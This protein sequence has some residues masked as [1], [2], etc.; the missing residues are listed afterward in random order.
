MLVNPDGLRASTSGKGE[1]GND[2]RPDVCGLEPSF[3]TPIEARHG[4]PD[5]SS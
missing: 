2:A 5:Y 4:S 1:G 3:R